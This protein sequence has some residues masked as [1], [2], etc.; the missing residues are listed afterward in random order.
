[1][2]LTKQ[3]VSSCKSYT[4]DSIYPDCLVIILNG[5]SLELTYFA[6]IDILFYFT[7]F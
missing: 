7:T 5:S 2:D 6:N 3:F 1:M 4:L